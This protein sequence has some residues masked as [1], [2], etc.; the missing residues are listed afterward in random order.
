MLTKELS[1]TR[2]AEKFNGLLSN[3]P[4]SRCRALIMFGKLKAALAMATES[5]LLPEMESILMEAEGQDSQKAI[6]TSCRAWLEEHRPKSQLPIPMLMPVVG[7]ETLGESPPTVLG[8][9]HYPA[10]ALSSPT[11]PQKN[12]HLQQSSTSNFLQQP[13]R[14]PRSAFPPPK[15]P[16]KPTSSSTHHSP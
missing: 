15:T 5:E 12:K 6:A 13:P 3:S 4:V 10:S 11:A 2:G 9:L 8:E 16:T 1:D 7:S 14:S